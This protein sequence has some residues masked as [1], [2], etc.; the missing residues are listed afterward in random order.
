MC[1]SCWCLWGR[2]C[3]LSSLWSVSHPSTRDK[4]FA[5][6]FDPD[7]GCN[8]FVRKVGK[9]VPE[10][11]VPHCRRSSQQRDTEISHAVSADRT[12]G[13]HLVAFSFLH[14]FLFTGFMDLVCWISWG[15]NYH[16]ELYRSS[17]LFMLH[18]NFYCTFSCY[19]CLTQPD[20][21]CLYSCYYDMVCG[22]ST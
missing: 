19:L 16:L 6:N 4:Q 2:Y 14:L 20:V 12:S 22:T 11:M 15:E 5:L 13:R 3:L 9:R 1:T 21:R 10:F 18:R 7:N 17:I 8:K